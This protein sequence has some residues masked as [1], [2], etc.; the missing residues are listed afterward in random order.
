MLNFATNA[1]DAMPN[2]GKFSIATTARRVDEHYISTHGYGEVGDYA[3]ITVSDTGHGMDVKTKLKVFDPFFTTKEV[4][5]GTGLGLAMVMG[6]IKQHGGFIDL[7]SE[8]GKGSVFQVYLP[9]VNAEDVV[10]APAMADVKMEKAFGA[11]LLAEDDV[12]IRGAM[13]ELL[14]RAGYTII[15]AV[16]GQDAVEKFAAR[17]DE[18]QLVISDVIMPRK[19]G[20][21]ACDEIRQM[22]DKTKF[23][24]VSGHAKDVIERE[25]DLGTDAEV[26]MKPIMP[27]E[28]LQR[29]RELMKT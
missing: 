8:S 22:S 18:I 17:K 27:F 23:I 4:G 29:I 3:V 28:L 16:D 5:K 6:I 13:V 14:S 19:S 9:L 24:F 10:S 26:I 20:K 15:T 7:K 11:I 12:D 2:G 21:D 25:G 1:R